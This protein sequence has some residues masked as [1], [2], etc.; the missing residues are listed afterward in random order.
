MGLFSWRTLGLSL[1]FAPGALAQPS[2]SIQALLD[3]QHCHPYRQITYS[4]SPQLTPFIE[5]HRQFGPEVDDE[6]L[7]RLQNQQW[8]SELLK[9]LPPRCQTLLHRGESILRELAYRGGESAGIAA[10]L[11]SEPQMILAGSDRDA[12]NALL[13]LYRLTAQEL[14]LEPIVTLLELPETRQ[15]ASAYLLVND[16][17]QA[18]AAMKGQGQILGRPGGLAHKLGLRWQTEL[19]RDLRE[20]PEIE[21]IHALF[22]WTHS[23]PGDPP[24]RAVYHYRSGKAVFLTPHQTFAIRDSLWN[25]FRDTLENNPAEHLAY[26][27]HNSS[28]TMRDYQ[29]LHLTRDTSWRICFDDFAGQSHINLL[30]GF[31]KLELKLR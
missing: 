3:W 13:A 25:D 24:L 12:Q 4:Q 9:A 14:P 6:I 22:T 2:E 23:Y 19:E 18:R 28:L 1:M 30:N 31:L 16:S 10:Y 5:P 20:H 27:I 11:L 15:A 21:E 8:D 26:A 17:P 7:H 29:Y